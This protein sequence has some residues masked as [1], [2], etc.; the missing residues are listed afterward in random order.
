MF[1]LFC[2]VWRLI[3]GYTFLRNFPVLSNYGF[4]CRKCNIL[5]C[6]PGSNLYYFIR[7]FYHFDLTPEDSTYKQILQLPVKHTYKLF[8]RLMSYLNV[9]KRLLTY[10]SLFYK[11]CCNLLYIPRISAVSYTHL[12]LPT[13]A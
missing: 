8:K 9:F 13:K 4:S 7:N 2:L 1:F 5:E 11:L 10:T 6:S 12:T 3:P